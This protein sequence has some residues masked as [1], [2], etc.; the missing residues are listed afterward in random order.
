MYR[1]L[2]VTGSD[3]DNK[4][5]MFYS[6]VKAVF[7][8]STQACLGLLT[9]LTGVSWAGCSKWELTIQMVSLA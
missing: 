8:P 3:T 5:Q 7:T 9:V 4:G 2:E 1:L 6:W